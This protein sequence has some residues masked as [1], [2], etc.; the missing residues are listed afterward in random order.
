MHNRK[1][2]QIFI[3][4]VELSHLHTPFSNDGTTD[5]NDSIPSP[6]RITHSHVSIPMTESLSEPPAAEKPSGV[7]VPPSRRQGAM[8]MG[9]RRPHHVPPDIQNASAFP[10]LQAS[11][12]SSGKEWVWVC[13]C[14]ITRQ[15][16]KSQNS[17][18]VIK[19][20]HVGTD[21]QNNML[22]QQAFD[23]IVVSFCGL[24][25]QSFAND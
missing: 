9:G 24:M 17:K 1:Q 22:C 3:P 20:P 2:I 10:S 4:V 6:S 14:D 16:T 13:L 15:R 18:K 8:S 23:V 7:Y 25:M 21:C 11:V 12:Q 19:I 5:S